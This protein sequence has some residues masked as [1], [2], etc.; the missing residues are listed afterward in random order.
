MECDPVKF[1]NGPLT[2]IDHH[3]ERGVFPIIGYAVCNCDKGACCRCDILDVHRDGDP[4]NTAA[5]CS[6]AESL[7]RKA[8]D[9]TT[10]RHIMRV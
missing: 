8:E 6:D 10:V 7:V 4:V 1:G 5:V 3:P 2:F 9:C